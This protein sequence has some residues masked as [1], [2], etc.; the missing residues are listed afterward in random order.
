MFIPDQ[1]YHK[2]DIYKILSVPKDKQKGPWNTGYTKYDGAYYIFANIDIAG[3]T[4]HDYDNHWVEDG[5]LAWYGR[6][7]SHLGQTSIQELLDKKVLVHIFTRNEERA[8]FRYRGLGIPRKYEVVAGKPI[9]IIWD[10]IKTVGERETDEM[11]ESIVSDPEASNDEVRR[12]VASVRRVRDGQRKMKEGLIKLYG[13]CCCITGSGVEE[14]LIACHIEPHRD[15]GNNHST[16]GLLMKAELHI[17]FD[18]NLIGIEPDTLKVRIAGKLKGSEYEYLDGMTLRARK[19]GG[20]PDRKALADR[21]KEF[22]KI[23]V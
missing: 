13:G 23:G 7:E 8:L 4:G 5:V 14:V 15:R 16:N 10:I 18:G 21:W 12:L 20:R 11:I 6:T 22:I 19:D 17:L 2:E 3:R 9:M 1:E